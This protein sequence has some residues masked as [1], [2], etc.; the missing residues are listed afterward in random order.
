LNA[1]AP[2][3]NLGELVEVQQKVPAKSEAKEPSQGTGDPVGMYLREM[4]SM[5]ANARFY[6][7][8]LWLGVF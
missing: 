3:L 7:R 6:A 5:G 8:G 4:A 1:H 2:V